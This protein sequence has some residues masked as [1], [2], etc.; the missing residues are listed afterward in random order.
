MRTVLLTKNG[1]L[2]IAKKLCLTTG[3]LHSKVLDVET[4][5]FGRLLDTKT[6]QEGQGDDPDTLGQAIPKG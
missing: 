5:L 2:S 3:I 6:C 1:C 4:I